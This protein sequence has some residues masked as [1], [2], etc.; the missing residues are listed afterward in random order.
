[1]N[2]W[3]SLSIHSCIYVGIHRPYD[4]NTKIDSRSPQVGCIR[5]DQSA[6]AKNEAQ[7][8]EDMV[9]LR[10][11]FASVLPESLEQKSPF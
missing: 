3:E 4:D 11:W 10:G 7:L 6:K 8:S 9:T 2:I 1:M 5:I